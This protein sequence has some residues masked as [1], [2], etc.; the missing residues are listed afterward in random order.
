MH[1][2]D[3]TYYHLERTVQNP[4]TVQDLESQFL[5]RVRFALVPG[6]RFDRV[7]L[8]LAA[9][10]PLSQPYGTFQGWRCWTIII[11][12]YGFFF[13]SRPASSQPIHN[14]LCRTSK[15]TPSKA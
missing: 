2:S 5:V 10:K 8:K 7:P 15:E 6:A 14:E 3:I 4:G 12:A 1:I 9:S 11:D 13:V